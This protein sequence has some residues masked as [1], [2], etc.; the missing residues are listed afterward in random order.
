MIQQFQLAVAET[1]PYVYPL[2]GVGDEVL[3]GDVGSEHRAGDD[4]PG[5]RFAAEEIAAGGFLAADGD[6]KSQTDGEE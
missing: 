3:G 6:E 5:E 1:M 4:E 2:P